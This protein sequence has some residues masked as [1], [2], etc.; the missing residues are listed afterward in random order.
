MS[1]FSFSGRPTAADDKPATT[2]GR[3]TPTDAIARALAGV[4]AGRARAWL[5]LLLTR[6]ERA[7]EGG[8]RHA[9]GD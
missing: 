8:H 6:G 4:P 2:D 9:H 5:E 1:T 3:A 7:A